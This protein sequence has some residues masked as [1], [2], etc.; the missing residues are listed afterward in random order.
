MEVE[1]LRGGEGDFQSF[2]LI[3]LTYS[4]VSEIRLQARD[5]LTI[6]VEKKVSVA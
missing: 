3:H 1:A 5:R 2:L 4:S 6:A